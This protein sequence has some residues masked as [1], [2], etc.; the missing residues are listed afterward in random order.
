MTSEPKTFFPKI[1]VIG[2]AEWESC[3]G[4]VVLAVLNV[5]N[6]VLHN[7]NNFQLAFYELI[8]GESLCKFLHC[9]LYRGTSAVR[10]W[11]EYLNGRGTASVNMSNKMYS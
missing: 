10:A 3:G 5:G 8:F 11:H 7:L 1:V 4:S 6:Y 9:L 2:G